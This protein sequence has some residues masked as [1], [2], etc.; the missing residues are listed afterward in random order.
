MRNRKKRRLIFAAMVSVLSVVG[1]C[2]GQDATWVFCGLRPPSNSNNAIVVLSDNYKGTNDTT[3]LNDHFYNYFKE[4]KSIEKYFSE[5]SGDT[6]FF[7]FKLTNL[8]RIILV[9][10]RDRNRTEQFDNL[11]SSYLTKHRTIALDNEIPENRE[12]IKRYCL[13][14]WDFLTQEKSPAGNY[15]IFYIYGKKVER[16]R[17]MR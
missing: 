5:N 2:F 10:P 17:R 13:V 8:G 1:D 3:C 15:Y 7:R 14:S 9:Q 12:K 16:H 4:N 11:I 6:L